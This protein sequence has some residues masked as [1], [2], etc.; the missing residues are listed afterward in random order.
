VALTLTARQAE[1]LE[2]IELFTEANGYPPSSR[3]LSDACGLGG[4][5]GAH[6]MISVLEAKGF[7]ERAHGQSRGLVVVQ[8]PLDCSELDDGDIIRLLTIV[9]LHAVFS[10]LA[11][12]MSVGMRD[13]SIRTTLIGEALRR[14]RRMSGLGEMFARQLDD[15]PDVGRHLLRLRDV[16]MSPA[17]DRWVDFLVD[18]SVFNR[19]FA[20]LCEGVA[21]QDVM[22]RAVLWPDI[23]IGR[24]AATV[25]ETWLQR[26]LETDPT[27]YPGCRSRA[28]QMTDGIDTMLTSITR[29]YGEGEFSVAF[30]PAPDP[31]LALT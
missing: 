28:E 20:S 14:S 22:R 17:T 5:S 31:L 3:E 1:I 6:R 7:V 29:S 23:S 4:P 24:A 12:S 26:L 18:Q 25:T 8:P 13:M 2:Q 9:E 19:I 27:L 11:L 10:D 30:V 15:L 16:V 21:D